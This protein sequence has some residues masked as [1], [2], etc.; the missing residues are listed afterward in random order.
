[1]QRCLMLFLLIPLLCLTLQSCDNKQRT[2]DKQ[3]IVYNPMLN[4]QLAELFLARNKLKPGVV[5]TATGLQY[6][7]VRS[8]V[9]NRPVRTD[10]VT[11]FYQGKF[12]NGKIFDSNHFQTNPVTVRVSSVIPGWQQ[13]LQLMQPGSIWVIFVPPYLAFGEKG[14]PGIIPPNQ[15]LIYTINLIGVKQG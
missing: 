5:T 1:M 15:G 11:V 6:Y 9:G 2:L 14:I 3:D 10:L 13:A 4:K 12:L 7:I 8:G